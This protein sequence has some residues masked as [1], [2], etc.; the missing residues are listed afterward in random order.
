MPGITG[1]WEKALKPE[2]SKP[3]YRKLYESVSEAY[4]T[5]TVYPPSDSVFT[6]FHLA[7][8]EKVKVV[9]LGQDPYHEP[10]E[11]HGLA[12]SV[13]AGTQLPPSLQNIYKE[14]QDDLG[15]PMAKGGDLTHWAE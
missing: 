5:R 11:A 9:I 2:F 8:L 12:F 6:A 13:K 3:Y 10:G 14:M 4:R 1:E 7:P 15:I